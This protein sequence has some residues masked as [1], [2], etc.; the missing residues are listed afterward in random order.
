MPSH[1]L[2]RPKQRLLLGSRENIPFCLPSP[3]FLRFHFGL[4]E[5]LQIE[6]HGSITTF[7]IT[8]IDSHAFVLGVHVGIPDP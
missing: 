2:T 4:D 1:L 7:P 8:L 6:R 3:Y 5:L